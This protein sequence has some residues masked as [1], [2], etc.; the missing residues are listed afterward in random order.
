MIKHYKGEY[1][2][3]DYNDNLFE[4]SNIGLRYIGESCT[5]VLPDGLNDYGGMFRERT[6][7]DTLKV[8]LNY[9][10]DMGNI[11][12]GELFYHCTFEHGVDLSD[13]CKNAYNSQDNEGNPYCEGV[14]MEHCI[15]KEKLIFADNFICGYRNFL[16]CSFL[17]GANLGTVKE[18]SGDSVE[19][20]CG[21]LLSDGFYLPDVKGVNNVFDSCWE[22]MPTCPKRF[23]SYVMSQEKSEFLYN[24]NKHMYAKRDQERSLAEFWHRENGH[25]INY[26]A[27]EKYEKEWDITAMK[28]KEKFGESAYTGY[29]GLLLSKE[30]YDY[31]N[32]ELKIALEK[33]KKGKDLI[34][35]CKQ[36]MLKLLKDGKSQKE[37]IAILSKNF[38]FNIDMCNTIYQSIENSL[39]DKCSLDISSIFRIDEGTSVSKYTVGEMKELLMKR[40]YSEFVVL[41]CLVDYLKD[42]YLCL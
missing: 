2:E 33:L 34:S 18:F 41:K 12:I 13:F 30:V 1:G 39:I 17:D 26:Q 27:V 6:F 3:C 7:K 35:R 16:Y 9:S 15:I 4:L 21:A 31:F 20:F 8:I 24:I 10:G 29:D 19:C 22:G 25:Q 37:A 11:L 40:G 5:V 36:E 42:E 28:I 23:P 32:K 14:F 38:D